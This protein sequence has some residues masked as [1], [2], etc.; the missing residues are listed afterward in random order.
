MKLPRKPIDVSKLSPERIMIAK[1]FK[2]HIE[3]AILELGE[4][5]VVDLQGRFDK[6]PIRIEVEVR[7]QTGE[8]P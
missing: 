2:K 5:Y 4:G 8:I 1:I 6:T 3:Q 7:T